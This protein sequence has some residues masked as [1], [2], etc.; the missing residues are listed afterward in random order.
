MPERELRAGSAGL[1]D[2]R[3]RQRQ[4][5]SATN[6]RFDDMHS[7]MTRTAVAALV[8]GLSSVTL[9]GCDEAEELLDCSQICDTQQECVDDRYNVDAC[10]DR[11]EEQSDLSDDFRDNARLCE[12]CIEDRACDQLQAECT[13]YCSPVI[14]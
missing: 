14:L 3:L 8:L 1:T 7:I 6:E 5:P 2:Q 9:N 11:C 10:T 4:R 12:A 13:Q